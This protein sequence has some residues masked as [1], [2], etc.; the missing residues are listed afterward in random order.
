[1]AVEGV[2][3]P[4]FFGMMVVF[5]IVT[6][7]LGL[8]GYRNTKNNQQF[9]LGR[10]K[11]NAV[12]IALSYG[13]TFLSASAVVGFGGQAATHGMT[14][15]W[16]CFLNLFLGLFVAFVLFGTRVRRIGRKLG[17][18]TFSDLLGKIFGSKK[19]RGFTAAIII[20][21]MPI[22]CAAVLKGGVNSLVVITGMTD[23]Y[24]VILIIL[25][26]IVGAYVVYGGIIAVMYNDALQAGIMIVG[27]VVIFIITLTT[28]GGF[29]AGSMAL[30]ELW[31]SGVGGAGTLPG[32]NGYT[33]MASFGTAEWWTV[34]STFLLGVGIGALTQ[35]QLVVRFMSAR[36]DR[37][38]N[39]SLII[40]SI[41]IFVIVGCAYTVGSLTNV[42]F[43]EYHEMT[44]FQFVQSIGQNV[45]F[46]IPN[47]VLDVFKEVSFGD[48]FVSLFLLTLLSAA[49]STI[50]AL[51]HTIGTAGGHDVYTLVKNW[52]SK[53][54]EEARADGDPGSSAVE[55]DHQS[56]SVNRMVTAVVMV[57]VVVYCYLMPGDI[58]AKATSLFMGMTAAAL[59]PLMAYG[60]YT[61]KPRKDVAFASILVGTVTYLFWALFINAGSS[62]FLPICRWIT[63]NAVLFMD[64][65][66]MYVDALVVALPLS[67]VT[68]VIAYILTRKKNNAA[69]EDTGSTVEEGA[70]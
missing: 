17:A 10:N 43:F 65:N 15:M 35:P 1:M 46:I 11:T 53:K 33:S 2:S 47:Y 34:V 40:G 66:I 64:S 49:I 20:I 28:L 48:V 9:L 56:L 14:L 18:S 19:I 57:L 13:A 42:Y 27:M 32:F 63:G 31:E 7:L 54:K 69:V 29:T 52:K 39:R 36:D 26:I 8:Y 25:A 23:L 16:L 12:I 51:M 6:I 61:K 58:I 5:V 22:Y 59:L 21:M 3:L 55:K 50:S 60:L 4:L 67:F 70:D 37:T 44:S 62:I 38:L 41:F 45:D 68:L 24:D 30:T